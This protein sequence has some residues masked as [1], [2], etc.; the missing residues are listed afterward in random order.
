MTPQQ[1]RRAAALADKYAKKTWSDGTRP[2]DKGSNYSRTDYQAGY[3]A[4]TKDAEVL[5]RALNWIVNDS[6]S[7]GLS[8]EPY[9]ERA[10]A[11]LA[12]YRAP[13]GKESW[14]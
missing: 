9:C 5:V 11:A 1:S 12:A 6:S 2:Y 10:R 3:E 14:A 7:Y 13:E 8:S 4:A